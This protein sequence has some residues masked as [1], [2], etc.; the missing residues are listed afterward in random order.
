MVLGGFL[1]VQ[2]RG[3]FMRR[4]FQWAA[5]TTFLRA[6]IILIVVLGIGLYASWP[7]LQLYYRYTAIGVLIL[8]GLLALIGLFGLIGQTRLAYRRKDIDMRRYEY[9]QLAPYQEGYEPL[10]HSRHG[11]TNIVERK[12]AA[13]PKRTIKEL[14]PMKRGRKFVP[15]RPQALLPSGG[16]RT[17]RMSPQ[18]VRT[19]DG[20]ADGQIADGQRTAFADGRT[21]QNGQNILDADTQADADKQKVLF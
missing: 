4:L 7:G 2:K 21:A 20:H 10:P 19:A 11:T 17:D 16:Q 3:K 8:L 15:S 12:P 18:A 5:D 1:C 13:L 6:D 14:P 9:E